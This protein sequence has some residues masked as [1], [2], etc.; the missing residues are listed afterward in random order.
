MA[1][2]SLAGFETLEQLLEVLFTACPLFHYTTAAQIAQSASSTHNL[3]IFIVAAA[4][5]A[6]I[7]A[8]RQAARDKAGPAWLQP[9]QASGSAGAL[10]ACPGRSQSSRL[11]LAGICIHSSKRGAETITCSADRAGAK[12]H[13]CG[14]HS[15]LCC[16]K[17]GVLVRACTMCQSAFVVHLHGRSCM[18]CWL[19]I[20]VTR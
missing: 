16:T 20:T 19:L 14:H 10:A 17:T 7:R 9:G 15:T 8:S 4:P 11:R 18:R 1:D 6:G 3:S 13:C 5:S 2:G 12:P